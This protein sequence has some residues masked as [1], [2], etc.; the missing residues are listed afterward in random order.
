MNE[1][2]STLFAMR[3]LTHACSQCDRMSDVK[4]RSRSKSPKAKPKA[5]AARASSRSRSPPPAPVVRC[6]YCYRPKCDCKERRPV[7]EK[8]WALICQKEGWICPISLDPLGK[9]AV[10]ASDGH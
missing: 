8:A 2:V 10:L 4:R 6:D 5:G 7:R 9:N 3:S 1:V